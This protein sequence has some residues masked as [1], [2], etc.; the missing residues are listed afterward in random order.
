MS[1]ASTAYNE[2]LLKRLQQ[3]QQRLREAEARF[4]R[5]PGSVLLLP[6]SK[7]R[8]A[9]DIAQVAA[10]GLRAFGESYLQEALDKIEALASQDLQWHFI[11]P[12]QSNKTRPIAENFHWV[13][14][15]D[16]LK[17]ARRLHEHRPAHLPALNICLQINIS[18]ENSKSGL[19]PE[20]LPPLLDDIKDLTRLKLRGLM[21][22]PAKSDDFEEQRAAF[23]R[24]R[25][26]YEDL[27]SRGL[28]L[29]T[30]S[31]GMS[32]DLEAAVAEGS[33]LVRVGTD[34][35]GPRQT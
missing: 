14:S 10:T 3:V 24:M 31:M 23:H 35:F 4:G 16:R 13:H 2:T 26:L 29:D 27:N 28:G 9:E 1:E 6:V 5:E 15:V 17:I 19:T 33:T 8:P 12:I 34:I 21:A 18:G 25:L 20:E 22:I 7:T 30:L 11:G 32:N